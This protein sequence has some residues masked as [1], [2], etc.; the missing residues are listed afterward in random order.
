MLKT[1]KQ[2]FYF[3]SYENENYK[4]SPLRTESKGVGKIPYFVIIYNGVRNH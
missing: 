4:Q 3:W 2:K 1:T